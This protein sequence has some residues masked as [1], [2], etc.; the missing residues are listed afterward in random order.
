[1]AAPSPASTVAVLLASF[2]TVAADSAAAS[3]SAAVPES[4]RA[5][6]ASQCAAMLDLLIWMI[7]SASKL[8][9][10]LP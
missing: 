3:S 10:L 5:R 2:F 7:C 6:C 9:L 1:M 8:K 4:V